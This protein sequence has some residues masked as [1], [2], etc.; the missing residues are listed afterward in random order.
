MVKT[1][2]DCTLATSIKEPASNKS[3]KNLL[4]KES[5]NKTPVHKT[6]INTPINKQP[7]RT[8]LRTSSCTSRRMVPQRPAA[9]SPI[10]GPY[11]SE[12]CC[13]S[14]VAQQMGVLGLNH[15]NISASYALIEQVKQF[16]ID[17]VGLR[18][19]ARAQLDHK[20]YWLYAGYSPIVHL[21]VREGATAASHAKKGYFNHISL[22]CVGLKSA[23]AK[24]QETHT[25]HRLI[26]LPDICQTQLF[27]TDPAGTGVELTFFNESF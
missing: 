1:V 11:F 18:L 13:Q 7:P 27:I 6:P 17:V 12:A 14:Q 22:S 9:S 8:S 25:P 19:G 10:S 23:I 26:E 15:F 20:G 3:P 24:L 2:L 5:P 16:Y 4:S 21:S